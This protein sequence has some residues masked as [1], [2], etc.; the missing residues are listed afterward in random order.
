[1]GK[2]V[3]LLPFFLWGTA[4]VVMKSVLP[5]TTPLFMAGLRLV[6]AGMLLLLAASWFNRPQPRTWRA[7]AWIGV[8]AFFDAFLFQLCLALG[9]TETGAGLGSLLIDSQPIAVAVLAFLIYK[10]K[11]DRY[12]GLGLAL[13]IVGITLVGMP[14]EVRQLV[15]AGDWQGAWHS[16]LFARGEW[17][18]LAASLSMAIGTILIRPVVAVA[19][20]V[21]A[22]G[23]HMVLG[24]LPLLLWSVGDRAAWGSLSGIDWAGMLYMSVMGSAIAYGLFFYFASRGNL[25]S[26]SALTFSTPMFALL[27]SSF[28][29]QER[30]AWV[31]WLGVVVTLGS[32]YLVT[33]AHD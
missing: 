1:M 2:L 14:A 9:L 15:L 4:M 8:F 32:I 21:V 24:G 7:W 10:E 33:R 13:G 27:F 22:T 17:F 12:C 6:P 19:D 11:I 20:P 30:L 16:G 25:T 3:L 23:W 18:M 26:L 29:L 31:Q 28:F 5:H